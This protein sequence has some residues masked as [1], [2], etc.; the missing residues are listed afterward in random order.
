M[1][2]SFTVATKRAAYRATCGEVFKAPCPVCLKGEVFSDQTNTDGGHI[3]ADCRGGP[4]EEWNC[5]P[6]CKNCNRGNTDNLWDMWVKRHGP[7]V[8]LHPRIQAAYEKYQAFMSPL[9]VVGRVRLAEWVG[10]FGEKLPVSNFQLEDFIFA[11]ALYADG[12][13][14]NEWRPLIQLFDT[15]LFWITV[16]DRQ[17]NRRSYALTSLA[18]WVDFERTFYLPSAILQRVKNYLRCVGSEPALLRL[19]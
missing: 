19:L 1:G 7:N 12:F 5:I 6:Q 10:P 18:S 2:R 4:L 9:E 13:P 3:W 15:T 8:P 16:C 11:P 17:G 14:L